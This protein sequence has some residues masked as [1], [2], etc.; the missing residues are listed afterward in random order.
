LRFKKFV[1]SETTLVGT[2]LI[3]IYI[4]KIFLTYIQ[5]F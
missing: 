2:L 5:Y 3:I 4:Y 1:K